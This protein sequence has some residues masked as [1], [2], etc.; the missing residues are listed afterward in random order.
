MIKDV[1]CNLGLKLTED[2]ESSGGNKQLCAVVLPPF[3]NLC[4]RLVRKYKDLLV[5]FLAVDTQTPP[6]HASI[7]FFSLL[8]KQKDFEFVLPL[9]SQGSSY[10]L[11]FCLGFSVFGS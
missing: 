1:F 4:P 10:M 9:F 7:F 8:Y 5:L 2:V 11:S 3:L 6:T